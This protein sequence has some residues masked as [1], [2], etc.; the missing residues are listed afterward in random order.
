MG[1]LTL[2]ML[3]NW[4]MAKEMILASYISDGKVVCLNE[5]HVYVYKYALDEK[6]TKKLLAKLT[7]T[8]E[9]NTEHWELEWKRSACG[10]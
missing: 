3:R 1:I 2:E 4:A 10:A 5:E 9:I 7:Q 6:Q 8:P